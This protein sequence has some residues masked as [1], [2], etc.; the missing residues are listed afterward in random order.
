MPLLKNRIGISLLLVLLGV[1]LWEFYA[2]PVNGPLYTAAV[3]E[4]RNGHY[5]KL[6]ELLHRTYKPDPNDTSVL[7]LM[8]WNDLKLERPQM[9][10]KLFTPAHRLSSNSPD[11]IPGYADTEINLG[12]YQRADE[13]LALLKKQGHDSA[14]IAMVRGSLYRHLGRN[15]EAAREFERVLTFRTDDQLALMNLRQIYNLKG[16]VNSSRLQFQKMGRLATLTCPFRVEGNF[17]EVTNRNA[18][19]GVYL[20]GPVI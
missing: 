15:Q 6:L 2:K 19:K 14:D 11:T 5:E 1:L 4:Y 13:L 8:G 18:W 9:A 7:T 12:H 3:N 16:P 20:T 17:F 10:L